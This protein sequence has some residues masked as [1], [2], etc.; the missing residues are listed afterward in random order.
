ME[1]DVLDEFPFK[2]VIFGF[3]VNLPGCTLEGKPRD[4]DIPSLKTT[5]NSKP[6]CK[7]S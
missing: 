7:A 4:I 6:F 2:Q 3:H 5:A 1:V